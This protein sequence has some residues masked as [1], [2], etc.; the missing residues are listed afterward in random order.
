M[1][2][3]WARKVREDFSPS[4]SLW[5]TIKDVCWIKTH[6]NTHHM[7]K[8]DFLCYY[9]AIKS[10]WYFDVEFHSLYFHLFLS[11]SISCAAVSAHSHTKTHGSSVSEM[12]RMKRDPLFWLCSS[13]LGRMRDCVGVRELVHQPS[14][15]QSPQSLIYPALL[16]SA[17][18]GLTARLF[19]QTSH[20]WLKQLE[21]ET[22]SVI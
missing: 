4:L 5:H 17:L 1:F 21:M 6:K 12:K 11:L 10:V 3:I 19:L 18:S 13:S 2:L 9:S 8:E 15:G 20:I 14:A 22:V 16:C 7:E